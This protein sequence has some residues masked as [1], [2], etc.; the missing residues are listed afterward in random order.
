MTK[1][2]LMFRDAGKKRY[3][4]FHPTVDVNANPKYSQIKSL[5]KARMIKRELERVGAWK[6][7]TWKIKRK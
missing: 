7:R 5:V 3:Y 1:Y 6:S 2:K 4:D